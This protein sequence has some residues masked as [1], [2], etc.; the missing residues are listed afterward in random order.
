ML[1]PGRWQCCWSVTQALYIMCTPRQV[2]KSQVYCQ[3]KVRNFP[4]YN[5]KSTL[6]P[7]LINVGHLDSNIFFC[8]LNWVTVP[9][10]NWQSLKFKDSLMIA[11]LAALTSRGYNYDQWTLEKGKKQSGSKSTNHTPEVYVTSWTWWSKLLFPER[12]HLD[13]LT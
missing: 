12:V 5:V 1:I 7:H 4:I 9:F 3:I 13:D 8:T 11:F 2:S 10:N 6:I